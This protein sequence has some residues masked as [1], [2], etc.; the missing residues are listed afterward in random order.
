MLSII[1]VVIYVIYC[2]RSCERE[3]VHPP[4]CT[5]LIMFAYSLLAMYGKVLLLLPFYYLSQQT[6]RKEKK[7]KKMAK[8]TKKTAKNG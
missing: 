4:T 2:P 8:K 7:L 6:K 1:H 5:W 3:L